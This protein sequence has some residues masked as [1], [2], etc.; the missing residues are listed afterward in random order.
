MERENLN[1]NPLQRAGLLTPEARESPN[2]SR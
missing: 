1:L 2:Y